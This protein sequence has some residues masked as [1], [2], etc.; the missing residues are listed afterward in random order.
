MLQVNYKLLS[1]KDNQKSNKT[2]VKHN[3]F[4]VNESHHP[5]NLSK[6]HG[7][8]VDACFGF[9]FTND[10][11]NIEHKKNRDGDNNAE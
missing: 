2:K 9:R 7:I 10:N 3:S 8:F 5:P 4:Y 1:N 11:N 6:S